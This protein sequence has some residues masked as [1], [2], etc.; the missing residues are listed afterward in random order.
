MVQDH[1]GFLYPTVDEKVCTDCGICESVCPMY[2]LLPQGDKPL[3]FA[4]W[5]HD[6]TIRINSSS[7]GVFSGV[8]K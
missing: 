4:A 7:G 6:K 3:S 1:E 2:I 8:N 5:S